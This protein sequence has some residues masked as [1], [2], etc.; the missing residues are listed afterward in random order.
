MIDLDVHQGDGTA[1]ILAGDNSVFTFS[2]HGENNYPFAKAHSDLDIALPNGTG[3]ADYITHLEMALRH[4]EMQFSADMVLYVAGL[5]AH[6]ADRLGKLSLSDAGIE[7][8]DRVVLQWAKKHGLPVVAVMA[9]GI[10]PTWNTSPNCN[11]AW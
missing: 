5:D 8:R 4:I 2:M 7:H 9:G 10:S 11:L 6:Q 3:D 1:E